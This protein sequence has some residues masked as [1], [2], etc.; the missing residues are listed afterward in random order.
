MTTAKFVTSPAEGHGL[1]DRITD[2]L[3]AALVTGKPTQ[4]ILAIVELEAVGTGQRKTKQGTH[5]NVV[6]EHSRVEI[7][8]DPNM[9][10]ELRYVSQALYEARTS[11]GEQRALPLGLG[12]DREKQLALIERI[13]DW[14]KEAG[15][16]GGELEAQWRD[17]FG[18]GPDQDWSMG[19]TGIPGDYRKAGYVYLFEFAGKVGAIKTQVG[20]DSDADLDE[21]E[22]EDDTSGQDDALAPGIACQV[23]QKKSTAL[24]DGLCEECAKNAGVPVPA[25]VT[26]VVPA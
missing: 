15:L 14:S 11:T 24:Y 17:T 10:N 8:T 6:F 19:D 25:D 26:E 5:R 2:P 16:T 18:I 23:C 7:V 1:T 3:Y 13:E 12:G 20:V 22:D 4:R 9:A 21:D